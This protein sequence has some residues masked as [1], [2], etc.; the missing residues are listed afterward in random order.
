VRRQRHLADG[1]VDGS[2]GALFLFYIYIYICIY[3]D[4]FYICIDLF[5][6]LALLECQVAQ[7]KNLWRM[8]SVGAV[9][10]LGGAAVLL[11]VGLLAVLVAVALEKVRARHA[12][13]DL[14]DAILAQ[15]VVDCKRNGG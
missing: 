2:V 8:P 7:K 3:I 6:V 5:S 9:S 12:A 13:G 14:G 11:D 1:A 4:V 10:L 15:V